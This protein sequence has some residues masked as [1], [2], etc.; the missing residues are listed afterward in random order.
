MKVRNTALLAWCIA[1]AAV[2][3]LALLP[4]DHL[5]IPIFDWWDKGQH[6]LAFVVL[7]AWALWL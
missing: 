3:T 1:M 7:T 5:Q 2:T 4:A 6:V